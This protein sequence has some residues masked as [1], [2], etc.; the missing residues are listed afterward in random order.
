[1]ISESVQLLN[2]PETDVANE[3]ETATPE[4]M[5]REDQPTNLDDF[6]YLI[7]DEDQL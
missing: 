6:Q 3:Q 5:K 7:I 1:M 4:I 2:Y